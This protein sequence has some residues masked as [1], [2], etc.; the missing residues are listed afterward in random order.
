MVFER[1]E[2]DAKQSIARAE[3]EAIRLG[4]D[5]IGTEHMLLGL[6]DTRGSVASTALTERG[7]TAE[8]AREETLRILRAENVDETGGQPAKDALA[9]LGIDV[10]EVRRRADATFGPGRFRYPRPRFT[11]RAKKVIALSVRHG[12]EHIDTEHLLLAILTE[13][14]GVGV[15]VLTDLRVDLDELRAGLTPG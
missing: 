5:F 8:K 3:Q 10:D 6:I 14:T 4:H 11:E 2:N 13:G 9:T 12:H 15:R 7:V 1:F